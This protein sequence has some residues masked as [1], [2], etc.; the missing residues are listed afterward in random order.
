LQRGWCRGCGPMERAACAAPPV[1]DPPC[2]PR[3]GVPIT[4]R[5]AEAR[6]LG[7][8]G[9]RRRPSR[10]G[11]LRGWKVGEREKAAPSRAAKQPTT[12]AP[13]TPPGPPRPPHP[14][15]PSPSHPASRTTSHPGHL[16]DAHLPLQHQLERPDL[17][18][19]CLPHCVCVR[20][21]VCACACA[22]ACFWSPRAALIFLTPPPPPPHTHKTLSLLAKKQKNRTCSRTSGRPL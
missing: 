19:A 4:V 5:G 20:V 3:P 6:S 14:P 22:A 21:C 12:S 18:G 16:Q 13:P 17:L 10:R 9:R 2:G 11:D 8:R 7:L 1:A 15:P